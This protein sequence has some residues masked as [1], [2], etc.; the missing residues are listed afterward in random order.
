MSSHI[1]FDKDI[2]VHG[3]YL[4]TGETASLSSKLANKSQSQLVHNFLGQ[5]S[6]SILDIGCGDGEYTAELAELN[7][8]SIVLG[9]DTSLPAIQVASTKWEPILNLKFSTASLVDLKNQNRKFD[10][11]IIR[12]VL[13]HAQNPDEILKDAGEICTRVIVL[14]PN[15]LNI[16]LKLIEKTSSYHIQH[17]ER[18]FSKFKITTWGSQAGLKRIRIDAGVLVP[19]FCPNLLARILNRLEAPFTRIPLLRWLISGAQILEFKKIY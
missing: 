19:F 17:G 14:E 2:K 10:V 5:G 3:R 4:Y 6:F 1:P 12:G 8:D 15:G 16:V 18:S 7:S 13:H 11:A 9:I